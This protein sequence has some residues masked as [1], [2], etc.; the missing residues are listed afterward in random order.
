M[1]LRDRGFRD[2]LWA[3][4]MPH[5]EE[6][7]SGRHMSVFNTQRFERRKFR[8]QRTGFRETSNILTPPPKIQTT[9]P[10]QRIT[11]PAGLL[12]IRSKQTGPTEPELSTAARQATESDLI[13]RARRPIMEDTSFSNT[14]G[15][16][17]SFG[18]L[19]RLKAIRPGKLFPK[20]PIPISI[21]G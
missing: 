3:P 9:D 5:D 6:F 21:T 12:G 10:R 4:A 8:G 7:R 11:R 15:Q 14:Q 16:K 13:R 2:P 20:E 18:I 17:V 1:S 19:D